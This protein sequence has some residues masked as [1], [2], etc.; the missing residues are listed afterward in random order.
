MAERPTPSFRVI[1]EVS[2]TGTMTVYA[3]QAEASLSIPQ[4]WQHFR[5]AHPSLGSSAKLYGASPSTADHK[6]HYLTGVEQDGAEMVIEG[7]NLTL[8]AGEYAVVRVD[9][10]GSLRDTWVYLLRTWLPASGRKERHAPEFERYTSMSEA[11]LPVGPVEVW[12]PLEPVTETESGPSA[13]R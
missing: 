1:G 7:E 8:E 12:I 3:S 6:I 5:S 13:P 2:L 11:G 4:Q 9:D 10:P